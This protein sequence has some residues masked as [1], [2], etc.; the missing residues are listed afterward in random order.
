MFQNFINFGGRLLQHKFLHHRT[1]L[2]TR[3]LLQRFRHWCEFSRVTCFRM[4]L[5]ALHFQG[6]GHETGRH[7]CASQMERFHH[8]HQFYGE[9]IAWIHP[10][11]D[12]RRCCAQQIPIKTCVVN[13]PRDWHTWRRCEIKPN[14]LQIDDAGR[15]ASIVVRY[16]SHFVL[17]ACSW[18]AC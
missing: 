12:R 17:I 18:G 14:G 8:C 11:R 10:G 4:L 6:V 5:Y 15:C 3:I 1:Q 9:P 13:F 2:T 7:R 16:G